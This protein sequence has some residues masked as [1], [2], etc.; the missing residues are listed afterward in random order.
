MGEPEPETVSSGPPKALA[1][2]ADETAPAPA[3][4]KEA[5]PAAEAEDAAPAAAAEAAPPPA[6]PAASAA[7]GPDRLLGFLAD[8]CVMQGRRPKQ[9]DRHVKVTDLTKAAK[10]MKMPI[11]H[12][13]QPCGLFAVYDGHQGV[14][15][16]EFVVKN[17]H[18]KLL[19]KLSADT[20]RANW[21]DDKL[22]KTLSEICEEL[23]T[24]FL[25]KYR[26]APDGCTVAV[27]FVTG[28]RLVTAWVGDSRCLLCRRDS[29]GQAATVMLTEDHKPDLENEAKRVFDAGGVVVDLGGGVWRVAHEGYEEKIR[30]IRRAK[31]QGLGTIA[32]EPIALAVSR[33]LGDREFKAVT[34]KALLIA[35]PGVRCIQLNRTMKFFAIMCDGIPD[36]M[37]NE[38]IIGSLAQKRDPTSYEADVRAACGALV[39][40]AYKRGSEDNLTVILVR[41]LWEGAAANDHTSFI[42]PLPDDLGLGDQPAESAAAASKRRRLAANASVKSQKIA[43]YDKVVAA[44]EEATAK[45]EAAK[46]AKAAAATD[47]EAQL[48][49]EPNKADEEP[50]SKKAKVD[51]A[52]AEAAKRKDEEAAAAKKKAEEK[53]AAEAAAAK[54]KKQAEE[55]AA[56]KKA[57]EEAAAKKAKAEAE[58]KQAAEKKAAEKQPP[59]AGAPNAAKKRATFV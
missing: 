52:E 32:K 8:S 49:S 45:L 51:A 47:K 40:E 12:L 28:L 21:T 11:D 59:K 19:K 5:T 27:A 43:A 55:E 7:G 37:R 38:E 24:E 42:Q 46:Q 22:C 48:E 30:D 44:E 6:K 17:F 1:P 56:A 50:P 31:A 18:G 3:P 57:A 29:R 36:V 14:L 10:A 23:D 20:E 33:A 39:Q 41:L 26:T 15:C 53:A 2:A 58:A 25:A 35:T 54:A 13:D 4:A 9:E 16:A 34:G